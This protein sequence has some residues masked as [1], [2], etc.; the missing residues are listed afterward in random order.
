VA[1]DWMTEAATEIAAGIVLDAN[2]TNTRA[3]LRSIIARHCPLEPDVAYMP[4]PRCETCR[5]W[6][7]WGSCEKLPWN[8]GHVRTE[9][10]FGCVKWEAK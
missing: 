6:T 10:D 9:P 2:I 5:H 1:L 7:D 8:D 3:G 4:V